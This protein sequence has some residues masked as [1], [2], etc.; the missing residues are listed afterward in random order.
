M[1]SGEKL[2]SKGEY[3]TFCGIVLQ[4]TFNA[5][6][7]PTFTV[8]L[9][10]GDMVGEV[11]LH[12]RANGACVFLGIRLQWLICFSSFPALVDGSLRRWCS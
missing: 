8:P 4:G 10:A 2:I 11:S 5:I 1:S 7:T 12:A 3:A 6:V 9:R